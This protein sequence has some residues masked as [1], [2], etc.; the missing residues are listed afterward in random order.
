[1]AVVMAAA[2]ILFICNKRLYNS[3][4]YGIISIRNK[5]KEMR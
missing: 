3:K 1:V 4:R 2:F 5:D